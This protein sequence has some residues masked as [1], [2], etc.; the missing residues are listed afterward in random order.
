MSIAIG[1]IAIGS[2]AIGSIAIGSRTL[3]PGIMAVVAALLLLAGCSNTLRVSQQEI[4][5]QIDARL[6]LGTPAGSPISLNLQSLQ[7]ELL[8]A[9]ESAGNNSVNH[10]NVALQAQVHFS[11]LGLLQFDSQAGLQGR[12]VYS[13]DRAAFFIEQP[14]LTSLDLGQLPVPE[15]DKQKLQANLQ[16]L[17]SSMLAVT[18][19]YTLRDNRA[20]DHIDRV[21]VQDNVMLVHLKP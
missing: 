21:E 3:K 16:Q 15:Q 12:L 2:I 8:A 7:C 13:P 14:Q 5:Q 4:Q 6:P 20:K 9:N 10:N 11:L 19:V 1:S 18:P 17:I